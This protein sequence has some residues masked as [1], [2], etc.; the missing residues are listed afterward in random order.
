M[1]RTLLYSLKLLI[2][3][4][5]LA[6]GSS[7]LAA[8]DQPAGQPETDRGVTERRVNAVWFRQTRGGY[9]GGTSP[10]SIR[11]FPNYSRTASIG[12]MEEF[13]N[14]TGEMWR[15]AA[16]IA[17]LNAARVHNTTVVDHEFVV[18]VSGHIDG[19]SAGM[20]TTVAML[21]S[22]RGDE[23][24]GDSTMT[25]TINPDGTAGTVGGIPHKMDG[26]QRAGITRFGYPVGCRSSMD[27]ATGEMVDLNA[28][29]FDLGM[30]A[31]EIFDIYD[32]YEFMTGV[33]LQRP[34][35][36][37]ETDM[38][39]STA[40]RTKV[41]GWGLRIKTDLDQRIQNITQRA[42]ADET[43]N[44]MLSTIVL[45]LNQSY[46]E[47]LDYQSSSLSVAAYYRF[48]EC[49]SLARA[50]EAMFDVIPA[51][52]TKKLESLDNHLKQIG[53]S[54]LAKLKAFQLQARAS[55]QNRRL[56]GRI[57]AVNNMN[58]YAQGAAYF[59][60]AR[61]ANFE[62]SQYVK[63]FEQ[64]KSDDEKQAALQRMTWKFVSA[65]LF[66]EMA[67]VNAEYAEDWL[68]IDSRL[69][70]DVD[71]DSE[72]MEALAR[73]YASAGSSCLSYFDALI[74]KQAAQTQGVSLS[75]VQDTISLND[76]L[77]PF[78]M[79]LAGYSEY[80]QTLFQ[81]R[82][83]VESVLFQLGSGME[84][85]LVSAG[86]VNKYYSLGGKFNQDG[87][88]TLKNRKVIGVMLQRARL[89]ALEE[90][91]EMKARHGF[92]PDS[93]KVNFQLATALREG[94]D[95]D[96]L[97]ALNAYWRAAYLCDLTVALTHP[98]PAN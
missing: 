5:C 75:V 90:A 96:K 77:Y 55:L 50:L 80:A 4:F 27:H 25:G 37:D 12:V 8:Q 49:D 18:K 28:R 69:G 91:G 89:R 74:T 47:A 7:R 14:G 66:Y 40:L 6:A 72:Q 84:A 35:A 23:I 22:L 38:D 46:Q 20:L 70:E 98:Q 32:A 94:S 60:M 82:N 31:Q 2:F 9:E 36:A 24:R 42:K 10:V 1:T 44:R 30:E 88:V 34:Q 21:A 53:M 68:A 92:I 59:Q 83:P 87:T 15:T 86:I 79:S 17:A 29:A 78:A 52:A 43:A 62:F 61:D 73:A 64:F 76:T 63:N 45:Q 85:Y 71:V 11:V 39:L 57:D 54:S 56:G 41:D 33:K 19:P 58:Q 13:Y 81:T 93:V 48:K 16:W 26:A 67:G 65:C 51:F 3:S 97:N 95:E